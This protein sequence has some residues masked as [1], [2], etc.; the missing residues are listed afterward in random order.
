MQQHRKGEDASGEARRRVMM[1]SCIFGE[2]RRRDPRWL[3]LGNTRYYSASQRM[4]RFQLLLEL[5]GFGPGQEKE[6][7]H[8]P[9]FP[10]NP[11][12]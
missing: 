8:E 12:H 10:C 3:G 9:P 1:P 5:L 7:A 11:S 6:R 4:R 2:T